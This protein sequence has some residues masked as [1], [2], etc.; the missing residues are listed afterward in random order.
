MKKIAILTGGGDCPGLNAVIRAVTKTAINKYKLEVIGFKD[1]YRGLVENMWQ[2]IEMKDVIGI[3]EKGGT[4]LGSSN[5]DNP[6][7][8]IKN[9]GDMPVD[10]SKKCI[11]NLNKNEVDCLIVIGGDGTLTSGRDF[12]RMGFPVIG[13]PKTIDN[14]LSA[15]DIT[16]GF[17]TA[18]TTAT[19]AI[20]KLRTTAESHHRVMVVEIM[21][22]YAGWLALES[23]IAGAATAILIPEIPY[24]I[25]K[26]CKVIKKRSDNGKSFSIIAVSEGAKPKDGEMTVSKVL[27]YSPDSIRLGGIANKLAEQIEERLHIETRAVTLGHIQRGGQTSPY[28]RVLSTRYGV[29]AIELAMQGVFGKM[30]ALQGNKVGYVSLEEAVGQ[31]KTVP[32]NC[33]LIDVA[34][35]IGVSFGD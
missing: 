17:N 10:M 34:R 18:V 16:F 22:R 14:D 27:D 23:G 28:D 3:I 13:V 2:P 24:D 6:F 7:A 35:S 12:S 4:I 32:P 30:V 15:T 25:D 21:G 5:R 33:E 31:L 20:D 29:K 19:E 8:Y 11:Q 1:G 9:R 26:L